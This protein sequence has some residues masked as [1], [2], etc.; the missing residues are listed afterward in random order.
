[1]NYWLMK[2]E[3]STFGIDD[4]ARAKNS[5]SSWDG[6]RNFQARNYIREMQKGDLAFFYHSSCEVPGIAGVAAIQRGRIPMPP[7]S[8]ANTITTIRTAIP[9][10]R[11]GT[12][13][14]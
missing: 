4:L 6:V 5:T 12:W 9:T 2:S 14:M 10:N 1:M 11:V 7:R 8:T 3:P 13:S